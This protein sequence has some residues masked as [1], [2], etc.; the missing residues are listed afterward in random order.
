M[1]KLV[2][3]GSEAEPT[4][5]VVAFREK[6]R[7]MP[8]SAKYALGQK[9][10]ILLVKNQHL[11]AKYPELEQYVSESGVVLNSNWVGMTNAQNLPA[12]ANLSSYYFYTLRLDK[13]GSEVKG[14]PEDALE[15]VG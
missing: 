2:E 14:V 4:L 15:L 1:L 11:R 5:Q 10:K 9:V 13:N 3:W 6:G 7:S 8:M 12:Q